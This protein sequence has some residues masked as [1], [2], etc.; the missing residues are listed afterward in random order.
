MNI[1]KRVAVAA[2]AAAAVAA[3]A[4]P[5]AT[6]APAFKCASSTQ[7]IN[8]SSYDGPWPDNWKITVKTC[9]ARC[10]CALYA[11]AEATGTAPRSAKW[12]M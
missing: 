2:L 5:T 4:A 6:A 9:A 11:Y 3:P 8:D 10:G 7:D 1:I 12:T